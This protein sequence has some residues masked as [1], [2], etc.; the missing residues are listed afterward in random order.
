MKIV[1][2]KDLALEKNNKGEFYNNWY[3]ELT[4]S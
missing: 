2:S 3:I 1:E 4:P